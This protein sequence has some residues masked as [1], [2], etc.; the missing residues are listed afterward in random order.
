MDQ[1]LNL[2]SGSAFNLG[3]FSPTE[4]FNSTSTWGATKRRSSDLQTKLHLAVYKFG[5]PG[6]FV[7]RSRF[8]VMMGLL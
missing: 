5:S 6:S 4:D 7:Q 1:A 2:D 8:R 3:P